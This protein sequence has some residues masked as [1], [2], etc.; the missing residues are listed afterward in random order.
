[1]EIHE[2]YMGL[3]KIIV[4]MKLSI[5]KNFIEPRGSICNLVGRDV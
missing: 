1:M 4:E 5:C 3:S 2:S